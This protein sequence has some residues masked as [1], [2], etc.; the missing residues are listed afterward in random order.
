MDGFEK[1]PDGAPATPKT[2][3]FS[4]TDELYRGRTHGG[5][6]NV[7]VSGVFHDFANLQRNSG[8]V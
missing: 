7:C 5:A 3:R 1:R 2:L 6:I 4:P 8:C